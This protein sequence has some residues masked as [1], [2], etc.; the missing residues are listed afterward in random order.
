MNSYPPEL[1]AQLAPIMFVA[2][3]DVR[4]PTALADPTPA[5]DVPAA[6]ALPPTPSAPQDAFDVLCLRLRDALLAQRKPA[7]W[8]PEKSKTFQAVFVDRVRVFLPPARTRILSSHASR[9]S[10]S[11][12]ARSHL[13]ATLRSRP[14]TTRR[15]RRSRRRR[16]CTPTVSSRRYGSASIRSSSPPSLYSSRACTRHPP[17]ARR[18]TLSRRNANRRSA[19]GT[20]SCLPISH[21]GRRAR[22]IEGSS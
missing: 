5:A 17:R 7:I 21:S 6:S 9:P 1:L 18:S 22:E 8:Q 12:R 15:S 19:G 16:R 2:G 20:R 11:R 13:R 10:A 3:L 14:S 4:V